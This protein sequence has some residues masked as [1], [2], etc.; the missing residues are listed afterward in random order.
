MP[1]KVTYTQDDLHRYL[2]QIIHRRD[3][4]RGLA[5]LDGFEN[6]S[7]GL[8]VAASCRWFIVQLDLTPGL[9]T[10]FPSG[11]CQDTCNTF[12]ISA[13]LRW[14]E[15]EKEMMFDISVASQL[16]ASKDY[17]QLWLVDSHAMYLNSATMETL[18]VYPVY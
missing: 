9:C 3:A 15:V 8:S 6:V 5:K 14:N 11:S 7:R 2:R 13:F 12:P 1:M 4:Y 10:F 18:P 16:L 17:I